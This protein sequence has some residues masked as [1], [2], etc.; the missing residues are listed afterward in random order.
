MKNSDSCSQMTPSHR[1]PIDSLT[2]VGLSLVHTSDI[3]TK[4]HGHADIKKS[5]VLPL[6]MSLCLSLYVATMSF[7]R[8]KNQNLREKKQILIA[9]AMSLYHCILT[10][11]THTELGWATLLS[12]VINSNI[13]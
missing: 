8:V 5:S 9:R 12:Y 2:T 10:K 4:Q 13:D 7:C 3:T 6:I 11:L 1:S